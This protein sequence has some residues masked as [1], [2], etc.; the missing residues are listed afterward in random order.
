MPGL[1]RFVVVSWRDLALSL[2]PIL[3]VIVA[4]A[5]AAVKLIQPAPPSTVVISAGPPGS[6]Y[7]NAATKYKDIL[8]KNGITVQ[9]L[10]SEGSA[11][12]LRRLS[13]RAQK[14]DVGFVQSGLGV[15]DRDPHLI[16]LGSVAYAPLTIA[17]RGEP[18]GF[19][20]DLKGK[21][22]AL[23]AEGSGARELGLALLKMNGIEPGGPTALLPLA[24]ADAARALM[25]GSVDAAFL[26]GESTEIAVLV[27]LV[28]TPGVHVF[29]FAQAE[30]YARRIP[31]L[32]AVTLPMGIYDLG[33]NLPPADVHTLAPTVELVARDTLHPALSDL[34]IEAA[35]AV[36]S[37]ATILQRA[38]EFPSPVSRN[39]PLSNDAARYYK[40]G[41][42]FLYSHLPFWVASL[43]DR[44]M[45]LVL[46]LLVVLIPASKIVPAI[47]RWR[48]RS[49]IY[50][51]YGALLAIERS[52]LDEHTA[53]ERA[54][55]LARLDEIEASVNQMK[56]PLSHAEQFYVLREHIGF[57]RERL[58]GP[59]A[60]PAAKAAAS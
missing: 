7:W 39:F 3:L 46:P 1:G 11:A 13:D 17:Y 56:M 28:R 35:R 47:Y 48:V 12:N 6:T 53:A 2:G 36:H 8:A 20:S 58:T 51:W 55:L 25:D 24:G 52:T 18:I 60:E 44:L 41:K 26:A 40:S 14:V 42:T 30:A 54:E 21:R 19:L 49:R 27:K 34:L 10:P 16:S 45:F 23:G 22:L 9:V 32:T 37:R 33:Q 38:D 57:V 50:R 31:Y 15:Q 59:V 5:W 29:S 4:V 43:A